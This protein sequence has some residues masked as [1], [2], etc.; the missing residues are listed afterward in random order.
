MLRTTID[1]IE[2]LDNTTKTEDFPPYP[3]GLLAVGARVAVANPDEYAHPEA[4][5]PS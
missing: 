2:P 5:W 1:V 3:S 4:T